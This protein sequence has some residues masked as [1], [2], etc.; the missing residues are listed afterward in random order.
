METAQGESSQVS[1]RQGSAWEPYWEWPQ[2]LVKASLRIRFKHRGDLQRL[3]LR[4]D[5]GT[6]SGVQQQQGENRA[7]VFSHLPQVEE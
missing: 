7:R 4:Q 6:G 2:R 5:M 1:A 3:V